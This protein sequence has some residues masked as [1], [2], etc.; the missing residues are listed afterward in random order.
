MYAAIPELL[1][2]EPAS[3]C[4]LE[5]L[6]KALQSA[7][8]LEFATLPPYLTALWSIKDEMH[9]AAVSI[10]EAVQEEMQHMAFACNMLTAIGGTPQIAGRV[11]Q[12]PAKGLPGDVMPDLVVDIDGLSQASLKTFL[13]IEQ[14]EIDIITGAKPASAEPG[15][16]ATIGEFYDAIAEAFKETNPPL[17]LKGQVIGPRTGW[18]IDSMHAV[19]R[20]IDTIK[21]QGEG[22]SGTPVDY[23]P[24]DWCHYY[25]FAEV[26]EGRKIVQLPGE[27]KR[28][29]YGSEKLPFPEVWPVAKLPK[30]GYDRDRVTGA[31]LHLMDR[32]DATFT[33]M[34]DD[35]Q[36]TW[37]GGDQAA[38]WRAIQEMFDL[39]EIGL[40]LMKTPRCDGKGNYVPRWRYLGAEL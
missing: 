3:R 31:V 22:S 37:T 35:I 33:R 29:A 26:A 11:P 6:K 30:G 8:T 25:R 13:A 14:P 17:S 12:Y 9:P 4:T 15:K 10:R 40:A 21:E 36:A 1:S 27:P 5:W 7:I 38:L 23:D 16:F 20:A 18:A 39:Q 19:L 34:V 32:F 24:A 2:Y 28:W